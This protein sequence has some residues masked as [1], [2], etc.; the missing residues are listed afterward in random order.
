MPTKPRNKR[1]GR[2]AP[3]RRTPPVSPPPPPPPCL[4]ITA[5]ELAALLGVDRKTVY[6]AARRGE[7]PSVRVGRR[8][9]FPRE[10]IEAW[11]SGRAS[12]R[13][14]LDGPGRSSPRKVTTQ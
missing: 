13:G 12:A 8:F 2:R 10:A 3:P 9:L 6:D 1:S 14:I 4:T 7:I 5:R 11:L